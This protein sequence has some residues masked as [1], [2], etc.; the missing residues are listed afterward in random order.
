MCHT[1]K[2]KITIQ[3]ALKMAV[4]IEPKPASQI[5]DFARGLKDIL[6]GSSTFNILWV[7]SEHLP[8]C[9]LRDGLALSLFLN[10]RC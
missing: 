6:H 3:R 2:H 9:H 8:L 7:Q 1:V 5:L 10:F 4:T